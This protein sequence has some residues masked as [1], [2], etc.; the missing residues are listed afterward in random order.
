MGT[1]VGSE[2][3]GCWQQQSCWH[4]G[5]NVGGCSVPPSEI[6]HA[7][8]YQRALQAHG[9]QSCPSLAK[10]KGSTVLFFYRISPC[11]YSCLLQP[12]PSPVQ[13]TPGK[14]SVHAHMPHLGITWGQ[15]IYRYSEKLNQHDADLGCKLLSP[16]VTKPA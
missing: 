6:P 8:W 7:P 16:A 9:N 15:Q 1:A 12:Q 4:S 13:P 14:H 5:D 10:P 11:G 2:K 3:K